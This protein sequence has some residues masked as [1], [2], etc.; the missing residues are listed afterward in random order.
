MM[1]CVQIPVVV[2]TAYLYH[3]II[4]SERKLKQDKNK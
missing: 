3:R 1:L 4:Q 2:I